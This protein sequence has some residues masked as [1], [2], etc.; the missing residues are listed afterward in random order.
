MT[1]RNVASD[2]PGH[3]VVSPCHAVASTHRGKKIVAEGRASVTGA[4]VVEKESKCS[5][6]VMFRSHYCDTCGTE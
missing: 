3:K 5:M 1:L 4:Q 6:T 2:V